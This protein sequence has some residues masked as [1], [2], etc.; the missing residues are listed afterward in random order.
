MAN[1][2]RAVLDTNV[3]IAGLINPLGSPGH[4][5]KMVRKQLFQLVS[6]EAIN[7]EIIEVVSRPKFRDKFHLEESL[8]DIAFVLWEIAELAIDPPHVKLSNDPDDDKFL[9]AAVGGKAD[10]LV[11][12][13]IGDL[14]HI[15]EYKGVMI[16]SPKEFLT[17]IQ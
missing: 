12:G 11:T 17:A 3:F 7:E 14:L 6:S 16:V 13:D 9:A 4:I 5:L 2:V 15:H 10:Y 8:F 1:K